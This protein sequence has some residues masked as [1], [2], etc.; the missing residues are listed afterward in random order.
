MAKPLGIPVTH[1]HDL[2]SV[3]VAVLHRG[4]PGYTAYGMTPGGMVRLMLDERCTRSGAIST[5]TA[6][7]VDVERNPLCGHGVPIYGQDCDLC[8]EGNALS[9]LLR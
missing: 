3:S 6:S 7:P 1:P 4:T 5:M 2:E 8:D 9:D